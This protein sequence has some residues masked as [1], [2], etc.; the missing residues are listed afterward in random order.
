MKNLNNL[1]TKDFPKILAFVSV[2]LI[3]VIS[4]FYLLAEGQK[5]KVIN[6]RLKKRFLTISR[7]GAMTIEEYFF[8]RKVNLL[9]L[10]SDF[11][12]REIKE[13]EAREKFKIL[14]SSLKD[15][16]FNAVFW[17]NK[18][19]K[20]TWLLNV[21]GT[22]EGEGIDVSD[23]EHFLWAKDP[24][25]F[26][27]VFIGKPVIARGG[28]Q[29]GNYLVAMVSPIYRQ[30]KFNGVIC[31]S[32]P[33]DSLIRRY[34]LPLGLESGTDV[35]IVREDGEII[36]ALERELIGKNIYQ[37]MEK[38]N[39]PKKEGFIKEIKEI[40]KNKKEGAFIHYSPFKNEEAVISFVP[41]KVNG[42]SWM[43]WLCAP[44]KEAVFSY[45]PLTKNAILG[46]ILGFI[47]FIF[48][49]IIFVF[50]VRIAQ[51]DGFIDGFR[52]GRNGICKVCKRK[53]KG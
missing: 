13:E 28:I 7:S 50:G 45:R 33:L 36:A 51:R 35:R 23:R 22:R 20:I 37:E 34:L 4:F 15:K 16:P 25:N 38:L 8:E 53:L 19:G 49:M 14:A 46:I 31:L 29:K 52:D 11:S 43:L 48:L 24:K 3:L 1:K 18:E 2:F 41:I 21:K 42:Y 6:E 26:G 5:E 12:Q 44:Y 40:I 39:F 17:V 32:F 27:K 10:A 9:A 30:G 47:I